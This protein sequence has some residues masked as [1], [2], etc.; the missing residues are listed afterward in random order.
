MSRGLILVLGESFR[1]GGQRSRIRGEPRSRHDQLTAL[2]SHTRFFDHLTRTYDLELDVV[3]ASYT[4]PYQSDIRNA[5]ARYV[6]KSTFLET[7]IGLQNLLSVVLNEVDVSPYTFV[8]CLRIDLFLKDAFFAVFNPFW[9]DIRFP[10]VCF[11]SENSHLCHDGSPRVSDM[12]VFVPQRY[13]TFLCGS[14]LCHEGWQILRRHPVA[15]NTMIDTYHDSDSQKDWNP[16]YRIVNRPEATTAFTDPNDRF[17][18]PT[19]GPSEERYA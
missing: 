3:V 18:S 2:A 11:K 8:L 10:S 5:Y 9:Q 1:T 6:R 14:I 17:V 4:T 16:L 12:M 13:S 15:V 19:S 7:P